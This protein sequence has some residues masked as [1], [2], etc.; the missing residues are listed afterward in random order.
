MIEKKKAT[1]R[2]G[3]L[4]TILAIVGIVLLAGLISALTNIGL[5][6]SQSNDR[7]DPLNAARLAEALNIKSRLGSTLWPEWAATHNPIILWNHA[8]E[9]LVMYPQTPPPGWEAVTAGLFGGM[10]YFRRAA[11][12]PQ[13][14]AMP[15]GDL[16]A[17]SIATKTETDVF[18]IDT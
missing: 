8:Y 14:F 9:F 2:T 5:P 13:N 17:A 11:L 4:I 7:L 1:R 15:V 10:P 6:Q 12:D 16:W 3:G 18:L